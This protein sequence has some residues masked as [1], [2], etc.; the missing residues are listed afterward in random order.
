MASG[1]SDLRELRGKSC[2]PVEISAY[3]AVIGLNNKATRA[4]RGAI[5][6]SSSSHLPPIVGSMLVKPITLPPGREKLATKP[7]PIGNGAKTMGMVRVCC[8][9]AAVVGVMCER[10]TSG[11]SATFLRES[12]NRLQVGGYRPASVDLDVATLRL[13]KGRDP[14]LRVRVA[15]SISHQH[16]DTPHPPALLLRARNERPRHPRPRRRAA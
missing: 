13:S 7:L 4:T 1:S 9:S 2:D 11:C 12:L 15:L 16:A 3:G 10:M 14:G 6:L 5:S 8:S